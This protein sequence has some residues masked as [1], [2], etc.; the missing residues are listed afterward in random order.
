MN[1]TRRIPFLDEFKDGGCF[2]QFTELVRNDPDLQ[3]LFRGNSGDNGV[4]IIYYCNNVV[5]KLSKSKRGCAR[6]T[7]NY[8]HL[9]YSNNWEKL[10]IEYSRYGFPIKTVANVK[11]V[12]GKGKARFGFGYVSKTLTVKE[13][14]GR[15]EKLFFNEKYV[16][17]LYELS[18]KVMSNY[19]SKEKDYLIDRFREAVGATQTKRAK[20]DYLEKKKQQLYF[21][22]NSY[23]KDG[24]FVYDLEYKEPFD[25]DEEKKR[26]LKSKNRKKMNKPD[27]LGIRFDENGLPKS[28]VFVELKSKPEAESGESGTGEHLDGM[29]DDLLDDE[30]VNQRIHEANLIFQDYKI[31]GL[32]GLSQDSILP[33]FNEYISKMKR[34]ILVV[35]TDGAATGKKAGVKEIYSEK[36]QREIIYSVDIFG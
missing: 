15:E 21:R 8:D 5:F 14:E 28:F 29:M 27:C 4:A 30:F 10:I 11:H 36:H 7:I 20:P 6:I 24:L 34:E 26:A 25:S 31:L 3:L 35:Y 32:K 17:S 2:E 19:F 9:R 13:T 22:E 12:D 1:K 33:D 23:L 18:R 16:K